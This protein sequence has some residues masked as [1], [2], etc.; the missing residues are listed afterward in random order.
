M[1]NLGTGNFMIGV[2]SSAFYLGMALGAFKTESF[3]SKFGHIR[4][5][6]VTAP[7]H[8]LVQNPWKISTVM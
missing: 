4:S 7:I 1:D 5:Y 2:A 8:L 6:T 3:V